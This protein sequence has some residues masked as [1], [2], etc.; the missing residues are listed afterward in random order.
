M[1][2]SQPSSFEQLLCGKGKLE[3]VVPPPERTIND[4]ARPA[5]MILQLLSVQCLLVLRLV[6]KTT[7]V[8]AE[9]RQ[10]SVLSSLNI[11]FP[12]DSI[13]TVSASA[14][15]RLGRNIQQLKVTILP[16]ARSD[17]QPTPNEQG[18]PGMPWLAQPELVSPT[19]DHQFQSLLAFRGALQLA[20]PLFLR[21]LT[22]SNISI[23]GILALRCGPFSTISNLPSNDVS[24]WKR[25][26]SFS[27]AIIPWWNTSSD[28][29][30][31]AHY[32]AEE[33]SGFKILHDWLSY[34]SLNTMESLRFEWVGLDEGPNPLLLDQFAAENARSKP[35]LSA[36]GIQ[37][38]QL[39]EIR[40]K[41]VDITD[42]QVRE[43]RRRAKGLQRLLIE[44]TWTE[45]DVEAGLAPA[46]KEEWV[47]DV[48]NLGKVREEADLTSIYGRPPMMG[49][50]SRIQERSSEGN[51]RGADSPGESFVTDWSHETQDPF[52]S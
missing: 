36:P 13:T 4:T 42:E 37:W 41:G 28:D 40:L 8:W 5:A 48:L 43:I 12:F 29:T 18:I 45:E 10:P 11:L 35:W 52:I 1:D 16:P 3:T 24:V 25:L 32:S 9:S 51:E 19:S 27:V 33:K 23:K 26:T 22:V 6:S 47:E 34:F 44:T 46:D 39:T 31:R 30:S 21:S 49:Q 50:L 38:K 17:T 7:K 14:L 20:S 15:L 2:A